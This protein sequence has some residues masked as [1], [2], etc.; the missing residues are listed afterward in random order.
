MAMKRIGNRCW[1]LIFAGVLLLPGCGRTQPEAD[2]QQAEATAAAP[3]PTPSSDV[4]APQSSQVGIG[5]YVTEGGWGRLVIE[6]PKSQGFPTFSLDTENVD[7]GCTLSGQLDE[8][9]SGVVYE[10]ATPSQCSLAL[11]AEPGGVAVNTSTK[12]QCQVYCGSNGSFE[13]S[14]KRVSSSCA[15]DAIEKA[16]HDFKPLYDQKKYAEAKAALAP[17]Y[18]N[19]VTT[20]GLAEEGALRNDYALT[21]YKLKDKSEC[22]SVLSKYKQDTARTDDQISDGMA[23]AVV[24]D[25][26]AVIHA[27]RTNIALCSR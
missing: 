7:S 17:I 8:S 18:Q 27:A 9:G 21:L 10:G 2:S 25:Y 15:A 19:C 13:G 22:L 5:T 16:R 6:A 23:P 12:A 4:A 24:D 11:K 26:L 14:Y 3:T 20:M 1:A